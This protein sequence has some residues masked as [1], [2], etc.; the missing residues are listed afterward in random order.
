MAEVRVLLLGL[1][2]ATPRLLRP[3]LEHMP[4][5]SE[6]AK[7]GVLGTLKVFYPTLSPMEWS[8]LFTGKNPGKTGIF[9]LY[10]LARGDLRTGAPLAN[11]A[12]VGEPTIW[13]ILNLHGVKTGLVN[14]PCIYPPRPVEGFIIS[15]FLAPTAKG[16]FYYPPEVGR[17]LREEG[18]RVDLEFWEVG[19]KPYMMPQQVDAERVLEEQKR[20]TAARV[21]TALRLARAYGTDFLFLII[22]GTDNVQH[23]F[24][25]DREALLDYYVFVDE[26]VAKLYD[27]YGPTHLLAVSD[28]GFHPRELYYFHIN[29]WLYKRGYLRLRGRTRFLAQA[30][31]Y[32]IALLSFRFLRPTLLILREE[33]LYEAYALPSWIDTEA[34]LAYA[35]EC[36]IFLSREARELGLRRRLARELMAIRGPGGRRVFKA[37]IER[38]ELFSGPYLHKIPDLILVPEPEFAIN[39]HF[40]PALFTR[41]VHKPYLTGSHKADN[42][43]IFLAHGQGVKALGSTGFRARITDVMPTTLYLY[44]APIPS[45][46]DGRVLTGI[47]E[48][49]L[50]R[51][52]EPRYVSSE[53]LK[54]M[55]RAYR[56]RRLRKK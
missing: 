3:F 54:I 11:L 2:G 49:A 20:I 1:D 22:K 27:A 40:S 10:S 8:A 9:Y 48:E 15:G 33:W 26:Q 30:L 55:L 42:E 47:F 23:L 6:L 31:A 56:L 5:F 12:H 17:A 52:R 53:R 50:R 51:A 44:G 43:G 29:T 21:R 34:S 35:L 19:I 36:G 16:R 39:P 28:H 24:W 41:Y 7:E 38:E 18:Y 13:D 46:V 4:F 45:D 25:H 37:V 14:V 32:N